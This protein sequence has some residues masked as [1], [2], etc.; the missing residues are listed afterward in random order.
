MVL[1]QMIR[2]MIPVLCMIGGCNEAG[3]TTL[4]RE[5]LPRLGVMRLHNADELAKVGFHRSI[6]RSVRF[7]R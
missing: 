3:K 1:F 4:A 6:L 5:L 2:P 7:G